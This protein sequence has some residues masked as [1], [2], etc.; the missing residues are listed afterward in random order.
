MLSILSNSIKAKDYLSES[1]GKVIKFMQ[2]K[3]ENKRILICNCV[4][5]KK[6]FIYSNVNFSFQSVTYIINLLFYRIVKK[7]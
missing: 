3:K 6:T 5:L 7:S 2:I 1:V 4:N